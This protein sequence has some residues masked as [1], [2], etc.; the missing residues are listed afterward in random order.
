MQ[1]PKTTEQTLTALASIDSGTLRI[2]L[3]RELYA[4]HAIRAAV[5]DVEG[6]LRVIVQVRGEGIDLDIDA[7]E[8]TN[9]RSIIGH[10]LNRLL[11]DAVR[12]DR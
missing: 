9:G 2:S 11:A 1:I 12:A 5:A 7:V 6:S 8:P 10:F 3:D 4:E